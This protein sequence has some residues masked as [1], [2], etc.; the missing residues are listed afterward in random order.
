MTG[1]NQFQRFKSFRNSID[2]KFYYNNDLC[3]LTPDFRQFES[4]RRASLPTTIK[5]DLCQNSK[6]KLR[7]YLPQNCIY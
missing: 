5:R 3:N 1:Q 7:Y 4:P 6:L 2:T